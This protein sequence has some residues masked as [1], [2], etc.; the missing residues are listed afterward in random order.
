MEIIY[1]YGHIKGFL[2]EDSLHF[3][4]IN[5]TGKFMLTTWNELYDNYDFVGILGL[6]NSNSYQNI[7][8]LAF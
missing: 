6:G 1:G 3:Q 4:G 5:V 7:F 8:D 2:A